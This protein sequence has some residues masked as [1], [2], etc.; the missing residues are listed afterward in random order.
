MRISAS[1]IGAEQ[2]LLGALASANA[3]ALLHSVRLATGKQ[4]SRPSDG[5][6]AFVQ[7]ASLESR[8]SHYGA[9]LAN[10]QTASNVAAQTQLALDQVRTELESIQSALEEDEDLGL[11]D[12]ERAAKQLEIDASL[13]AIDELAGSTIEGRRRLDGSSDYRAVGRDPSEVLS[14]RIH[15]SRETDIRGEVTSRATRG[16]LQYES[17]NGKIKNDASFDLIGA[18]GTV[19]FEFEENDQLDDVAEA[20]NEYSY[21]TGVIALENDDGLEFRTVG[22]G[23]RAT[24]AIDVTSGTFTTTGGN[25]DGTA[26]GGDA[27]ARINDELLTGDGNRFEY[28]RNGL[29]FTIEFDS[30][31]QGGFHPIV[32]DDQ[33]VQ[34][35]AVSPRAGDAAMLAIPG[36]QPEQFR[37]LSG[38]LDQ[39]GTGGSLAGL[40]SNTSQALWVVRESLARLAR[41]EGTV[42]GFADHAIA[43]S[44]N[45]LEGMSTSIE[46]TLTAINGIDEDEEDLLVA[47]Y[48]QLGQNAV[49]SLAV[50]NNQR[51][52]IV[53]LLQQLAG[54]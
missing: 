31:F 37:G 19:S 6:A 1:I 3:A 25:G 51:A 4:I 28:N 13:A 11:T 49:S 14:I 40:G 45:L 27:V 30:G 32:V 48:E 42:D 41:I 22:Y 35:F 18:E 24:I 43:A 52:S 23:S 44:A 21:Q 33:A 54:F 9:T 36:L 26:Q 10:V 16:T 5:P 50:F 8:L 34:R 2:R 39:L 17:D 29:R 20:I 7:I 38:S 53:A 46:D 47:R 15:A 12:E